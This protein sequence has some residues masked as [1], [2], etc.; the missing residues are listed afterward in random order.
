MSTEQRA[1]PY[2]GTSLAADQRT[3]PNPSCGLPYPFDDE[4]SPLPQ[5]SGAA[6]G[7]A[8]KPGRPGR[9]PSADNPLAPYKTVIILVGVLVVIVGVGYLLFRFGVSYLESARPDPAAAATS[10]AGPVVVPPALSASPGAVGA[11]PSPGVQPG[12]IV[13]AS[14]SPSPAGQRLK[15]ANTEG[16]GANMRQRPATSAPVLR[17]LPEG[18]SVEAIGGETNADGR[19]W[20]NVRDQGGATGWV[21]SELLV[22]E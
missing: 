20:R 14:P 21:A 19:A 5:S 13:A 18:A 1:C 9:S 6:A 2:C 7:P 16:Q 15:V 8:A 17:T 11:S 3:C 10:T 22:P 12:A 4:P